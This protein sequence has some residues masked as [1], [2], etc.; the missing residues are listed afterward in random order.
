MFKVLAVADKEG[1]AIDRLCKMVA[2]FHNNIDYQVLAVHPKRPDA[3]QLRAFEQAAKTADVI[4]Y[5]YFRTAD[6]LRNRYEWLKDIPSILTHNNPYSIKE[7]DWNDYDVVVA[8]NKT[9]YGDLDRITTSR[10]VH[11]PLVV[12]PYFWRYN[13]NYAFEKS[14]IM[15]ANRIES[16]KGILPVAK[17][18]QQLGIKMY[19]VGAISS[20]DY[21]REV[22]ATGVVHFAQEVTDESLRDLYHKAGVHVCNS[23]DNFESGT[24]PILESMFCGVPVITREVGHVPDIKTKDNMIINTRN[25]EDIDHIASLIREVLYEPKMRDDSKQY[26]SHEGR[27][28][29]MR[30]EAWFSIKDKIPERRAYMY[31]KLYRELKHDVPV[32]VIVPLAGKPEI[33]RDTLN[34]IANQTH[35]NIEI[36]VVDDGEEDQK[37]NVDQFAATV[38]MPVRYIRLGGEQY[39]I[40]QARNMAAIEATSDIL[41]FCDQRMV[42]DKNAVAEFVKNLKPRYWLYGNKGVKKEFV[43][44]F[45]C[46]FRDDFIKMGM[47]NERITKYGGMSQECRS[48]ARSQGIMTEFIETAKA[49]PKG[50]SSNKR[51]KKYE[52]MEMKTLL[53]KVG[54]Q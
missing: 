17:A 7:R 2:P 11:I 29:T 42:M 6:M 18:C 15:V 52:I 3:E 1:T 49:A 14:V 21:W 32:S 25:P 37:D 28:N 24:L 43:E 34:S 39:H 10:L 19:L 23:V 38:S 31:Q 30:N 16:K 46:I 47:F 22:M 36:I 8:N 20:P 53:W 12:D 35:E 4:D 13:D 45:S 33:T 41:V 51:N 26:T 40:A 27:I 44:N 48:R 50:K 9:M 5:Q 54:L